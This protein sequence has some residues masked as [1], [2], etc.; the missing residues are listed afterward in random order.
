[1]HAGY[2]HLC[3]TVEMDFFLAVHQG[4]Y[5]KKVKTTKLPINVN[6]HH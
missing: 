1:M 2:Y 5:E 6:V 4:H 3:N